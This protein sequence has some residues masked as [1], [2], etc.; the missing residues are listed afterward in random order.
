MRL[1][2]WH[3][4]PRNYAFTLIELLVVTAIITML[5]P[6]LAKAKAQQ[7]NGLSSPKQTGVAYAMYRRDNRDL[8]RPQAGLCQDPGEP[9]RRLCSRS[10]R[11]WSEQPTP[12]GPKETWWAAHD[13]ST[14][15]GGLPERMIP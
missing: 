8:T 1:T 5:L 2:C 12:T 14:S 3:N 10:W 7:T 4:F 6:A 13:F 15:N 11:L 9:V